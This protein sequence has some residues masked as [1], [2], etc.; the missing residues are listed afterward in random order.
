[1]AMERWFILCP[2]LI[3]LVLATGDFIVVKSPNYVSFV[4]DAYPIETT[5][6]GSM[7][8]ASFGLPIDKDLKWNGLEEINLFRRPKATAVISVQ[9][10]PSGRL[11]VTGIA[12]YKT[13]ESESNLDTADVVRTIEN[14]NWKTD[15]LTVDFSLDGNSFSIYSRQSELF[16]GL[17]MT[18]PVL[19]D[20]VSSGFAEHWFTPSELGSLNISLESDLAFVG[21]LY[22][23]QQVVNTLA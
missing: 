10:V 4:H 19:R 21:E 11:T 5:E 12:S 13:I 15:P 17:P 7:I 3:G 9:G 1:M 8:S 2:M 6:I 20:E 18:L 23:I 14:I 22:L 16:A